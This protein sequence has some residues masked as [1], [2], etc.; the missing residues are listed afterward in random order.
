[1]AL[2]DALDVVALRAEVGH[3]GGEQLVHVAHLVL[4]TLHEYGVGQLSAQLLHLSI[5]AR[6]SLL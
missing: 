3:E 5:G 2:A 4:Q 6:D 1:M